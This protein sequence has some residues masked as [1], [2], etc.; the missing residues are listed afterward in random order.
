[1]T[2]HS[3]RVLSGTLSGMGWLKAGSG[4]QSWFAQIGKNDRDAKAHALCGR[5][6]AKL[7]LTEDKLKSIRVPIT[8]LVGDEDNLIKKLYI[9][10]LRQ[11]RKDW[12]VIEIKHANHITCIL[13]PQFREEIAAW[14]KKNSK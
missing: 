9:E 14:L 1:M 4:A 10:P 11:V 8:V 12:P 13:K 6:L 5:S 7:A 2:K 3:D